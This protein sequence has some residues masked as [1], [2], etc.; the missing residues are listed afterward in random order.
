MSGNQPP[1]AKN[2]N[3]SLRPAVRSFAARVSVT[4]LHTIHAHPSAPL[5][6]P[7]SGRTRSPQSLATRSYPFA[8]SSSV[9]VVQ[10]P[11][12]RGLLRASR[13]GSIPLQG[14][15]SAWPLSFFIVPSFV[16]IC[17]LHTLA[18]ATYSFSALF[19]IGSSPIGLH[20]PPSHGIAAVVQSLSPF[21]CKPLLLARIVRIQYGLSN[22]PH[23][24]LWRCVTPLFACAFQDFCSIFKELSHYCSRPA[25]A[26]PFCPS[27]GGTCGM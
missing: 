16:C 7:Y 2:A 6:R 19:P 12:L 26:N 17:V 5:L 23:R 27:S 25:V 18:Q 21:A 22:V 24:S 3:R 1:T 13:S 9:Y 20:S 11:Y 15:S 8:R 10:V 4:L 14:F